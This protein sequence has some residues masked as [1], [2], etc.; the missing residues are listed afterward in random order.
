MVDEA[1]E[2]RQPLGLGSECHIPPV[3]EANTGLRTGTVFSYTH[4]YTVLLQNATEQHCREQSAVTPG[5][6]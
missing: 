5:R 3:R 1:G 6:N 2:L 4:V